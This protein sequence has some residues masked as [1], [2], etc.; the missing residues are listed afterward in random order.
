MRNIIEYKNLTWVD[1]IKPSEADIKYLKNEFRLHGLTLKTIIPSIHH[2]DL[3]VFRNY[4]SVILHY[5]RNEEGQN[6]QIYELDIIVGKNYLITNHYSQI[7]PL[8]FILEECAS[9]QA[10]KEEYMGN[11]AETLLFF[12]LSR[13]LNRI[14]E[15]VDKIG[16]EVDSV[17]KEIFVEKE[18]E[19]VKKISYLKR[20]IIS[21]WRAIDPQGEVFNSLETDGPKFFGL[22][23]KHYFSTLFRM[24]KRIDSSLKTYKEAIESLEE[25]NHIMVN[26]KMNEI[27]KILTLFSAFLLPL[28]L[29]ASIWGMNTNLLPFKG[30]PF[31]FWLI[32]GLMVIVLSGM[33]LYFKKRKWL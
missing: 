28:T 21:F 30:H 1:I 27:I 11:G 18:K 4:I 32:V 31:D 23:S 5:P 15:K 33:I 29:L 9:S 12:I 10:R 8:N 3:D 26:L 20:R 13:F 6:V 25:T 19:M 17:E 7:R 24:Y 16:E 14:L 22:E 2:P